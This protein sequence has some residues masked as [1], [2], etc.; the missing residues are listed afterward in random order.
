MSTDG[1]GLRVRIHILRTYGKQKHAAEKWGVSK[2]FISKVVNE[3]SPPP[4]WLLEEMGLERRV[5][6]VAT[7][8]G[9]W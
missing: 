4:A 2:T 1:I 7:E 5:I 6:Y 9:L 8:G 3:K